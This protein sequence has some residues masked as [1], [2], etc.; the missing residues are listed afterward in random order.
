MRY[1]EKIYIQNANGCVRNKDHVNI[2]MSSDVCIF[3]QP[4][5]I[6]T[7]ADKISAPIYV[8]DTEVH[9]IDEGE[10]TLDL[11]F[12][13]TGNVESFITVGET[14]KYKIYKFDRPSNVFSSI[15]LYQS[16]NIEYSGF[17]A[18]SAFTNSILLTTLNID[19]EYLVKGSYDFTMCTEM[20]NNLG[21]MINTGVPLVGDQYGI[22]DEE[23]DFYFT[24]IGRAGKPLFSL[25]PT[26]TRGLGALIVESFELSG[27]TEIETTNEWSGEP[28]VALNGLTLA[29]DEDYTTIGKII[30]LNGATF[31]GDILTVAYVSNGNPN[32]LTSENIVVDGAIVSGATDGEGDEVIYYN[33]DTGNYEAFML[34]DPLAF[35]D[36]IVTLNGVTLANGLDYTQ[37]L[38]NPRRIVFSGV[39]Y[40]SGDLG[41]GNLGALADIITISYNTYGTYVGGIQYDTFDL[42]WTLTPA[43]VDTNGKFTTLVAEDNTY[44]TILFSADTTYITNETSYNLT[45]DISGYTGTTAVYKV[46]NR[47]D[48]PLISGSTITTLTDSEEIPIEINV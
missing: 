45:V 6:M 34:A 26:D 18:T 9:I 15:P 37:S 44:S 38:T 30:Y 36:V 42:Y 24:A 48:Y 40:S 29:E 1:Q 4:T 22:Y 31:A 23:F 25:S 16:A 47:K 27:E 10:T 3:N 20:M 8:S 46:T 19:G 28:I 17:S 13:F 39:I 35:N 14:F 5:F 33:T 11:T 7:G 43:P 41:D 12:T 2:S 32:G 21:E